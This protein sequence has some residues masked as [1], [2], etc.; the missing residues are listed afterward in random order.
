MPR[1]RPVTFAL[2]A[3]LVH[4]Q[5][6]A[7]SANVA[8]GARDHDSDLPVEVSS[9]QLSIDQDT[10]VVVFEGNVVAVQ[11]ELRLTARTVRVEY[12]DVEPRKIEQ[13]LASGGVTLVSGAE[14]AEA[15]DAIYSVADRSVVMTGDVLLTQARATVSGDRLVVDLENGTGVME[16][17]VRTI[18]RTGEN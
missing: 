7:Q 1:F 6:L 11:G 8:F 2:V 3:A 4:G 16:G 14:A 9:D 17:R 18:L 13:I 12:T 15:K 10:G 5:A